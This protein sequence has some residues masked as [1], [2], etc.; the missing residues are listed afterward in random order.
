MQSN[1]LIN[2]SIDKNQLK[3]ERGDRKSVVLTDFELFRPN[4]NN[5]TKT[6]RIVGTAGWAP[7]EQWCPSNHADGRSQSIERYFLHK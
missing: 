7:P 4:K 3:W 1:I 6:N 5:R 2:V